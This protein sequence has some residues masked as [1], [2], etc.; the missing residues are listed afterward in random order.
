VEPLILHWNGA[1]WRRVSI[2]EPAAGGM[3]IAGTLSRMRWSG[4]TIIAR[5]A[6]INAVSCAKG[7]FCMA[8]SASGAEPDADAGQSGCR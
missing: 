6:Y 1:S 4:H 3:F 5:G 7:P 2:P 8:A